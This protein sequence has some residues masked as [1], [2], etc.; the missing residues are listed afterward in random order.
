MFFFNFIF[1]HSFSK[2]KLTDLLFVV[3]NVRKGATKEI[4]PSKKKKYLYT[5]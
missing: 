5:L 4:I 2:Y 3:W 1:I